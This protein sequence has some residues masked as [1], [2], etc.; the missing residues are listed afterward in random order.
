MY[1]H[2]HEGGCKTS[3]Q[4]PANPTKNLLCCV[5]HD[6]AAW[7]EHV[8]RSADRNYNNILFTMYAQNA[9]QRPV[10]PFPWLEL[11]SRMCAAWDSGRVIIKS[12]DRSL[13]KTINMDPT[14]SSSSP[15]CSPD[16][17]SR[18]ASDMKVR[19]TMGELIRRL[20]GMQRRIDQKREGMEG[21]T[22]GEE[23]LMD[24]LKTDLLP[25]LDEG[26][27]QLPGQLLVQPATRSPSRRGFRPASEI[28]AGLAIIVRTIGDTVEKIVRIVGRSTAALPARFLS[29]DDSSLPQEEIDMRAFRRE[30]I[31]GQTT[32]LIHR[33]LEA[34]KFLHYVASSTPIGFPGQRSPS[35]ESSWL[36]EGGEM[37]EWVEMNEGVREAVCSMR[38][39]M[40]RSDLA[41]LQARWQ[42]MAGMVERTLARLSYLAGQAG[43]QQSHQALLVRAAVPIVKL[44]RVFFHKLADPTS[45]FLEDIAPHQLLES[46]LPS[47]LQLADSVNRL[48]FSIKL[49]PPPPPNLPPLH[50]SSSTPPQW[51]QNTAQ[52]FLHTLLLLLHSFHNLSL[53]HLNHPPPL[54]NS[55]QNSHLLWLLTCQTLVDRA[56]Q[57]FLHVYLSTYNPS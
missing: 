51:L 4:Q 57:N 36:E 1:S 30:E 7:E 6:Q 48:D 35:E 37:E 27:G 53:N 2:G 46:L 10:Q 41:V 8:C 50:I 45:V 52:S 22:E 54:I 23:S 44:S 24:R 13:H 56:F 42:A 28:E 16:D 25:A 9:W 18:E 3:T 17:H 29:S 32:A 14:Q 49:L 21:R 12:D 26:L 43:G 11:V 55:L 20:E 39:S 33:L 47:T 38:G 19:A 5:G 15:V 34:F 31:R 40:A